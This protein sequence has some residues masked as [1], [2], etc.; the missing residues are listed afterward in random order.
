MPALFHCGLAAT[1]PLSSS[2]FPSSISFLGESF[3][4][5]RSSSFS[6]PG[7][8]RERR[9]GDEKGRGRDADGTMLLR[10]HP[11]SAMHSTICTTL[12]IFEYRLEISSPVPRKYLADSRLVTG[13]GMNEIKSQFNPKFNLTN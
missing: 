5:F 2:S 12:Q 13:R 4:S 10:Q 9:G 1:S 11:H 6:S 7:R 3:S 8:V